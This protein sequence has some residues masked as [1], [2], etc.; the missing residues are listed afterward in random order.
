MNG[1]DFNKCREFLENQIKEAPENKELLTAYQ[2]LF[3]LKNNSF[4]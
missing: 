1:E 4:L 2:R 3:E